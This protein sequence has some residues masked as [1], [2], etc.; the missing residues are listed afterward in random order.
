MKTDDKTIVKI[1]G[2]FRTMYNPENG[3]LEIY[4]TPPSDK[5]TR[6]QTV[7]ELTYEQLEQL[8]TC[9]YETSQTLKEVKE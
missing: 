2:Q 3:L 7:I 8:A 4:H 6:K 9:T 5:M 1:A